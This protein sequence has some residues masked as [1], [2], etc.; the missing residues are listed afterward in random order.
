MKVP[1]SPWSFKGE[2]EEGK[3]KQNKTKKKKTLPVVGNVVKFSLRLYEEACQIC[4]SGRPLKRGT[5]SASIAVSLLCDL[6]FYLRMHN[7]KRYGR[8]IPQPD[9]R[10]FLLRRFLRSH[11]F[12]LANS[13]AASG[14][15]HSSA[16]GD[17]EQAQ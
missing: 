16:P 8:R 9:D 7:V 17:Q 5:V 2:K 4:Q 12:S 13:S 3:K 15:D 14:R 11:G 6:S 10:R 1:L